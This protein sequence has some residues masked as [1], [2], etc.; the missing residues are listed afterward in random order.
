VSKARRDNWHPISCDRN[1]A[2]KARLCPAKYRS[3]FVRKFRQKYRRLRTRLYRQLHRSLYFSLSLNLDLDLNPSLFGT[4]LRQLFETLFQQLFATLFGSMFDLKN[5]Q[6][7][8][9]SHLAL[10]RQM[11][12]PRQSVGRG[13]GGRIVVRDRRTTTNR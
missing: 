4:L 12:L 8:A 10:Y 6:L 2:L 7:R 5:V 9:S 11:P 1:L 13:V 3:S